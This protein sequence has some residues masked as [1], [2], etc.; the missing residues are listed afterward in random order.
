ME[1][2]IFSYINGTEDMYIRRIVNLLN[3][4]LKIFHKSY[5]NMAVRHTIE[6]TYNEL[7]YYD[8]N[9]LMA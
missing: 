3:E 2:Y 4:E 6:E 7:R 8:Y 9:K 1:K 5:L